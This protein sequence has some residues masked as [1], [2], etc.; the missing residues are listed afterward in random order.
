LPGGIGTMDE[1]FEALTLIQTG[2]IER[3]P[4]ILIGRAYW[5]PLMALFDHLERHVIGHFGMRV[6]RQPKPSPWL[7]ERTTV[8]GA[9]VS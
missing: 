2:K 3:F 9:T 5:Q 1:L 4:L 8:R 7:G 6:R